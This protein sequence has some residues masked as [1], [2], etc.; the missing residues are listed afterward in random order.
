MYFPGYTMI[1]SPGF[2]DPVAPNIV[3]NGFDISPTV[4]V[5]LSPD[6]DINKDCVKSV[7]DPPP[8]PPPPPYEP[9]L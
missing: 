7:L 9:V 4:A 5:E 6:G 3:A 2:A 8:A 1:V